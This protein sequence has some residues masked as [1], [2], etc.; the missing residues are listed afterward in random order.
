MYSE[1]GL[2]PLHQSCNYVSRFDCV[3]YQSSSDICASTPETFDIVSTTIDIAS[4]KNLAQIS[5]MLSQ[6]TS[7]SEFSEDSPAYL[8]VNEYIRKTIGSI[9]AWLIEGLSAD[10]Q[11]FS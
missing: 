7:G 11:I 3:H 5:K 10:F 6:I 1:V 8:P 2:L 4:R 9:S